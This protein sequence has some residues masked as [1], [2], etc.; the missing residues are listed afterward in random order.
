VLYQDLPDD[1]LWQY[2][3]QDDRKAFGELFNR[4]FPRLLRLSQR[5]VEDA[6]QAEELSMDM[7]YRLWE[8]R[9]QINITG[10]VSGYLFRSMRNLVIDHLRKNI[11]SMVSLNELQH[12]QPLAQN[13]DHQLLSEEAEQ[14]YQ[15]ALEGLSPQ[16]RKVFVLSRERNLTYAEIARETNLSINTVERYMVSALEGIRKH[17]E[18]Y[19]PAARILLLMLISLPVL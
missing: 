18:E 3:R 8:K 4:F 7:L 1:Q 6:M 13:A 12:E 17:I 11:R 2:C 19:N 5:Y 15:Q 9:G 10:D 14:I 16:R